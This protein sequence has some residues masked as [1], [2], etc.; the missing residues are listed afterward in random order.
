MHVSNSSTK[1]NMTSTT[2]IKV[3]RRFVT[4]IVIADIKSVNYRFD[5]GRL[6]SKNVVWPSDSQAKL[7]NHYCLHEVAIITCAPE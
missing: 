6:N 5:K 2:K 3:Q 7:Q 4:L 1:T